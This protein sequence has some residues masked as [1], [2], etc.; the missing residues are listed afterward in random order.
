MFTDTEGPVGSAFL[1]SFQLL[2]HQAPSQGQA[3][4][5]LAGVWNLSFCKGC[6]SPGHHRG[7]WWGWVAFGVPGG[8]PEGLVVVV[9][10]AAGGRAG[11]GQEEGLSPE[12]LHLLPCSNLS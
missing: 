12:D 1:A 8:N 3:A 5:S 7:W 4:A 2:G 10:A 11:A 6:L 9:A